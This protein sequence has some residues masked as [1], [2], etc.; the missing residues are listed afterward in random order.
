[1]PLCQSASHKCLW[2]FTNAR[3]AR[4]HTPL[5]S[6]VPLLEQV[7]L[8]LKRRENWQQIFNFGFLPVLARERHTL[9]TS[10]VNYR[11][12]CSSLYCFESYILLHHRHSEK[13]F[14]NLY[15]LLRQTFCREVSWP[16]EMPW[17]SWE[18]CSHTALAVTEELNIYCS[19]RCR[20]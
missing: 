11:Y 9:C 1:M 7:Q 13:Q 8:C 3:A 6:Q 12:I 20:G 14:L 5:Q 10:N 4:L 18:T 17:V 15:C 2:E 19:G 16:I